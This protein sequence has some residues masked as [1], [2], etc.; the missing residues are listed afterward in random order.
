VKI[1]ETDIGDG[2]S[3]DDGVEFDEAHDVTGDIFKGI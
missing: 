1:N 3:S 2:D